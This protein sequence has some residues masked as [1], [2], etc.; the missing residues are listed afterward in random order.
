MARNNCANLYLDY[1]CSLAKRID[2]AD[3]ICLLI[4]AKNA[5]NGNLTM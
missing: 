4:K 1:D 3:I 5:R 2:F